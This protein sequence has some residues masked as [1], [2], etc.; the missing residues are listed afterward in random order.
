MLSCDWSS[1]VCSSDLINAANMT[2]TAVTNI[3]L[4]VGSNKIVISNSGIVIEGIQVQVKGTGSA[5]IEAPMVNVEA[6]GVNTIKG[7]LVKIN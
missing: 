5:K 4:K 7:S 6:S 1:D 3:T 2:L